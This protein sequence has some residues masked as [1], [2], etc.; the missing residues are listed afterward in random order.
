MFKTLF[1]SIWLLFHPVHVT[2]TSIDFISEKSAF[3]VFL[4]MYFDDFIVDYRL[5]GGNIEI[6]K[7]SDNNSIP[8]EVMEKYLNEKLVI[9]VND[10]QLTGILQD[11]NRNE[12]EISMN[13]EYKSGKNPKTV[14]VK[15]LIMTGLY[16]DQ[17]NMIILKVNSFE[18]GVKLTSDIT[19]K[20]FILK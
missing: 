18:E 4:R 16:Q 3:K 13:L 7:N 8:V 10:I 14:S 5:S 6:L 11:L 15:N 17:T 9:K 19:E 12:N 2:I 1:F 20:T